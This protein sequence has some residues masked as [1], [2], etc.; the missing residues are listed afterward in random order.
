MNLYDKWFPTGTRFHFW[1]KNI[2]KQDVYAISGDWYS[3]AANDTYRDYYYLEERDINLAMFVTNTNESYQ[4]AVYNLVI[5]QMLTQFHLGDNL[6]L[7]KY[8][9]TWTDGLQ[10]SDVVC[11]TYATHQRR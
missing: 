5:T 3:Y 11:Y 10:V 4:E 8:Y 1:V 6:F 2:D 9:S 7:T